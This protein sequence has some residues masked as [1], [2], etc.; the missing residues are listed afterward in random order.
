MQEDKQFN[1]SDAERQEYMD[2]LDSGWEIFGEH[3]NPG[4]IDPENEGM[5]I[6]KEYVWSDFKEA[7]AFVNGLAE[8]AEDKKHH[9][10]IA[11]SYNKVY[12]ELITHDLGELT[13]KDFEMAE[14]ID[15]LDEKKRN[16]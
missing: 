8:L 15:K 14:L 11:I 3:R 6:R 13:K 5:G 4:I 10:D 16:K 9:P 7:M 1:L 12:V 2:R